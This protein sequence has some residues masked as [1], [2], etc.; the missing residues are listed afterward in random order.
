M[1]GSPPGGAR[2]RET[3]LSDRALGFKHPGGSFCKK[4][5]TDEKRSEREREREREREQ[6]RERKRERERERNKKKSRSTGGRSSRR[7]W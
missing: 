3:R 5:P 1:T 7:W 2:G 6:K 4:D